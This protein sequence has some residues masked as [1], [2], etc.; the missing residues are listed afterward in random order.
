[1][2]RAQRSLCGRTTP[3]S[4]EDIDDTIRIYHSSSVG[5]YVWFRVSGNAIFP[6]TRPDGIIDTSK[7]RQCSNDIVTVQTDV[8][9]HYDINDLKELRSLIDEAIE[10]LKK[11]E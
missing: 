10:E 7:F 2:K 3:P 1:M 11:H 6:T 5:N 4:I 8:T 9:H